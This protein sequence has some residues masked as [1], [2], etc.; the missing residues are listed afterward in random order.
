MLRATQAGEIAAA[1]QKAVIDERA[2]GGGRSGGRGTR[3]EALQNGEASGSSAV[4]PAGGGARGGGRGGGRGAGPAR[5]GRGG[6]GT[7]MLEGVRK[8]GQPVTPKLQE[9]ADW[10]D[11]LEADAGGA[12]GGVR[13]TPTNPSRPQH[14]SPIFF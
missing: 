3:P 4:V 7:R 2:A 11:S 6:A 14:I 10:L 12:D 8:R 13:G 5:A 1:K 9:M